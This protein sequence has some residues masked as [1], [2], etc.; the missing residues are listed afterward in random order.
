MPTVVSLHPCRDKDARFETMLHILSDY[1]PVSPEV[2]MTM[3]SVFSIR[4]FRKNETLIDVGDVWDK[5]Y[6]INQGI[7]RL[8]YTTEDGREFN[9]GF[10][11]ERQFLNPIAPVAQREASRFTIAAIEPSVVLCAECDV[12]RGC[13]SRFGLWETFALIQAEWLVE[14]KVIREAEFLLDPAIVRFRN[15]QRRFGDD[16][17]RIPDYH[18]ASYLGITNVALSRLKKRHIEMSEED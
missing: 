10:F 1:I 3:K 16:L 8:F 14:Q 6:F 12:F 17:E 15:A 7:M 2:C 13:L 18:I 9:K 5:V 4:K 11:F